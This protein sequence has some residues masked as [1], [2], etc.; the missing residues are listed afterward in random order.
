MCVSIFF[1]IV[2]M[3]GFLAFFAPVLNHMVEVVN[4]VK[5]EGEYEV[6]RVDEC[7]HYVESSVAKIKLLIFWFLGQG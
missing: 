2:A 3:M 4:Q 6:D 1:L 5:D 7:S